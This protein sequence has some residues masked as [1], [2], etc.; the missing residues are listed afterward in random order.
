MNWITRITLRGHYK[1][2]AMALCY[3]RGNE[4]EGNNRKSRTDPPGR[5]VCRARCTGKC[6]W[7]RRAKRHFSLPLRAIGEQAVLRRFPQETGISIGVHRPRTASAPTQG[8][9]TS[10]LPDL[11]LSV[12]LSRQRFAERTGGISI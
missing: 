7:L 2:L 4:C 12:S 10:G 3:H 6:L 11:I 1:G 8:I 9:T 5:R